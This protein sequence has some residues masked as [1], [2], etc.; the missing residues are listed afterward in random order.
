MC[1]VAFEITTSV[2]VF[3]QQTT[4]FTVTPSAF[5]SIKSTAAINRAR[6]KMTYKSDVKSI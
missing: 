6:L 5:V 2:G 1:F 4:P 3:Y